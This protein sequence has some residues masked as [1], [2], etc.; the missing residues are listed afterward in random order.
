MIY[1]RRHVVQ[2]EMSANEAITDPERPWNKLMH[3][4]GRNLGGNVVAWDAQRIPDEPSRRKV[5]V[6]YR[7]CATAVALCR[8]DYWEFAKVAFEGAEDLRNEVQMMGL[9][10]DIVPDGPDAWNDS[11]RPVERKDGSL[12]YSWPPEEV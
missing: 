10:F 7:A 3:A 1:K 9:R 12:T 4:V 5:V 2:I 6:R 11:M 8:I